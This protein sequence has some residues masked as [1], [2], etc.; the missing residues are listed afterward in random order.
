MLQLANLA[1][2]VMMLNGAEKSKEQFDEKILGAA[3]LKIWLFIFGPHAN[4]ECRSKT[5]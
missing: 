2:S 3:G 4:I 5:A 1:S